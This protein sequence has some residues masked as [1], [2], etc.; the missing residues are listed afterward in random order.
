M[1]NNVLNVFCHSYCDYYY[2]ALGRYHYHGRLMWCKLNIYIYISLYKLWKSFIFIPINSS[3]RSIYIWLVYIKHIDPTSFDA[4]TS[5]EGF[6]KLYSQS[7]DR[8][9]H[10]NIIIPSSTRH[11]FHGPTVKLRTYILYK[12]YNFELANSLSALQTKLLH[13]NVWIDRNFS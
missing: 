12:Y 2:N 10:N 4:A 1:N 11:I 6:K 7:Y 8:R 13:E 3:W 9:T 5:A